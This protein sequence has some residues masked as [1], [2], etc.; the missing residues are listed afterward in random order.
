[1]LHDVQGALPDGLTARICDAV[2]LNDKFEAFSGTVMPSQDDTRFCL[3]GNCAEINVL[4]K[5]LISRIN[6]A[7][8]PKLHSKQCFISWL[9]ANL[10]RQTCDNS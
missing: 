8:C 6:P 10:A 4:S 1:M 3:P 9:G 5:G 2:Y 7:P